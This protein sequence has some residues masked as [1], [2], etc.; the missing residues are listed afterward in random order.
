MGYYTDSKEATEQLELLWKARTK[1]QRAIEA[2][3]RELR[4]ETGCS[5]KDE[6]CLLNSAH[7]GLSDMLAART[8]AWEA[9]RDVADHAICCLDRAE[10]RLTARMVL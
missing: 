2:I 6:E 3:A 8:E 4:L 9:Q 5:E 1:A 10:E 7:D